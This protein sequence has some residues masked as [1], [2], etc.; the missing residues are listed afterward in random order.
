MQGSI[1]KQPCAS[2]MSAIDLVV[3]CVRLK[4]ADDEGVMKSTG[5][6]VLTDPARRCVGGWKACE[7]GWGGNG[8]YV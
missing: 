2:C 8:L 4:G 6:Y 3:R 5:R 7:V 1:G